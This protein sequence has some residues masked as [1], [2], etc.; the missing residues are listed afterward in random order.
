MKKTLLT[1]APAFAGLA[2]LCLSP[3]RPAQS[4]TL[5]CDVS[6][7]GNT[8]SGKDAWVLQDVQDL[9]V[10]PD[11]TLFTN[12]GWDEAGGNVQ[13]YRNGTWAGVARHT[14]G[15]GYG[16]GDAVAA[17]AKYLFI[18]Q[19]VDSEGGGLK[20]DSWPQKGLNWAGVSRRPRTDITQG[21]PFPGGRGKEGDVLRESFLPVAEF[22]E[23]K[24]GA[25]VQ[26]LCADDQH[27]FVSSPFDGTVK[28]YDAETMRLVRSW[29]VARP[30]KSCLDAQ[31]AL[32]VLQRPVADGGPWRALHLG[33][34][35]KTL[36]Q[37]IDFP[38]GTIPTDLCVDGKKRLLI[39]D[40]G[41]DQQIKIYGGLDAKPQQVGTLGVKG[42]IFARPAGRFGDRRFNR[43]AGVGA[44]RAGNVYVASGGTTGGGSTVLECY[45]PGDTLRWRRLGLLFVD[46]PDADPRAGVTDVFTKEEHFTLGGPGG[47]TYRSYTVNPRK[48]PDDPRLH[49]DATTAWVRVLSGQRFLFTTE[50]TAETLQ[51][52]RFQPGTDGE[53]AIPCALFAKRHND[54]EKHP[55]PLHQPSKGEWLW[56]DRN[57]DGAIG[58]D[59][60]QTNGGAD[61]HGIMMPDEQGTIWQATDDT[62]RALPFQGLS[63]Q[64]VPRWGYAKARTYAKPADLDE[65]RRLRYLPDRDVMLL[66]GNKGG[67]HNQHWKP[68]GPVL[69]VYDGWSALKPTLRRS[70]VLPYDKG[71]RGHESA[72]PI[73]FDVA[74]DYVFVAY[75]RG[76]K[77]NT[78]KNAFVKVLR[79]NDLSEVGDLSAEAALGETGLLDL[80]ESVRALRRADGEYVIFLEDDYKAKSIVFRWRPG[81]RGATNP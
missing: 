32:W 49:R 57:G 24:K 70:V 66:G 61:S 42:G 34:G 16:G 43:P 23:G 19:T 76:L 64:G 21:A 39:S 72:E 8:Y 10:L 53:T 33:A 6:W 67:D 31:G 75:T 77:T 50:M 36:P 41:P 47:G 3:I 11:G 26:G 51:V 54:D 28:V 78:F 15:W 18:A 7:L 74:G 17:N 25:D 4:Q 65:V 2:V 37:R 12:A 73:S 63:A 13:E 44:D 55:Y 80:V 52:F 30:D 20:G 1:R 81:A 68:M 40:A 58:V 45:A 48:Y 59:E 79:L 56:T 35:G 38:A 9:C 27:L 14:H 29:P 46:L 69:C 62:I 22:P 60:F 71:S 5:P